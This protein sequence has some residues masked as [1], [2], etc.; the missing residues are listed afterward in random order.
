MHL[1]VLIALGPPPP[2]KNILQQ[3]SISSHFQQLQVTRRNFRQGHLQH[4]ITK[5]SARL[6]EH[7]TLS[8]RGIGPCS[9]SFS[10]HC[11]VLHTVATTRNKLIKEHILDA[12]DTKNN[13]FTDAFHKIIVFVAVYTYFADRLCLLSI[14]HV[15]KVTAQ[16]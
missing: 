9:D 11:N 10:L 16:E 13:I 4:D 15:I 14:I 2:A 8:L 1:H 5:I 6:L 12:I 7:C 3:V